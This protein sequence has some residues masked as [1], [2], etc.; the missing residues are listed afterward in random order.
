MSSTQSYYTR[1]WNLGFRFGSGVEKWVWGKLNKILLYFSAYLMIFYSFTAPLACFTLK[2]WR[3]PNP[4]QRGILFYVKWHEDRT[5]DAGRFLHGVDR[6]FNSQIVRAD[7]SI[8]IPSKK[9]N[10]CNWFHR[11]LKF[12]R[13]VIN[14]IS[15]SNPDCWCLL[16]Y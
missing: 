6:I 3:K 11:K 10:T 4:S 16:L 2:K 12:S 5:R 8:Q 1:S 14:S 9:T 13:T 7:R 15:M